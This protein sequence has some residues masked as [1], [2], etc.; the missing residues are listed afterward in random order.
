MSLTDNAREEQIA[1]RKKE[2]VIGRNFFTEVAPCTRVQQFYGQ[3]RQVVRESSARTSFAFQFPLRRRY[4]D[5]EVTLNSFHSDG[6]GFCLISVRDITELRSAR[7]QILR[8]ER[9]QEVGEVAAGV[10]HNFNNL[11]GVIRGNA[12]L[13]LRKLT[14]GHPERR[15]GRAPEGLVPTTAG[16]R[17]ASA[18]APSTAP[19]PQ[20]AAP[21][22]LPGA[23]PGTGLV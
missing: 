22:P 4:R 16:S 1:R 5:V 14:E 19:R 21:S 12:E 18:K 23:F 11:L 8:S 7:D 3:F 2:D 10:A 17:A 15:Q 9:L 20:P 13:L 6:K